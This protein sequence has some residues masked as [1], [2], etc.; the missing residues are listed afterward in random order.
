MKI[1]QATKND[2]SQMVLLSEEKRIL[3]ES[4]QPVFWGK[5]SDSAEQQAPYFQSFLSRD[6]HISLVCEV[7]QKLSGFLFGT[8][9]LPPPVY[10][11]G[12]KVCMIDDFCISADAQWEN[13]GRTLLQSCRK[14][15]V[16]MGAVQFVIV[17]GKMD[18]AKRKFL[19]DSGLTV[20]SEW[21]T[22]PL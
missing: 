15:A 1:R 11:A 5:A 22:G 17:C 4:Y 2:V 10:D 6:N 16:A 21:Y 14:N 19:S 13:E 18:E 20:A 12:G 7:G 8:V 9:A 3:Y